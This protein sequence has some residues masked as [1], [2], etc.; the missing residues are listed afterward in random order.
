MP[1]TTLFFVAA[2][3]AMFGVFS[4]A[5]AY[6]QLRTRGLVAPGALPPE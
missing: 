6:V 1:A 2:I 5:L 3:L 4:F